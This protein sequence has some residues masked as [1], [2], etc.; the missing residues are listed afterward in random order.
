MLKMYS[1]LSVGDE[2]VSPDKKQNESNKK[3]NETKLFCR[4]QFL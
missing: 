2:E 1:C 3:T 4:P